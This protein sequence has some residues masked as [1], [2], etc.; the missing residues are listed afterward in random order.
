MATLYQ[1]FFNKEGRHEISQA[2][3]MWESYQRGTLK[4]NTLRAYHT[5][6]TKLANEFAEQD[7]H[8]LSTDEVFS[9]LNNLTENTKQQTKRST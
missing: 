6:L 1:H 2:I 4:P 5:I 8:D 9:F 3:K 7:C